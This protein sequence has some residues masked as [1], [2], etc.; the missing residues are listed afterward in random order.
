MTCAGPHLRCPPPKRLPCKV[1]I[2]VHLTAGS[3]DVGD[4]LRALYETTREAFEVAILVDPA[5]SEAT[6]VAA[7]LA[8]LRGAS[9]WCI[10]APGGG[11]ASF[12]KLV[13]EVADVYVFLEAGTRPGPG[14]LGLMLDALDADPTSGL[15]GPTTDWC[16][17]EQGD[18]APC[19]RTAQDVARHA[20][21]LAATHGRAW[22]E[23][24]PLYSL[25]DFCLVVRRAVVEALGE[26]DQSYG[27]GPC[28]EMD[29]GVRAARAGFASIWV[30]AAYVLRA[31]W[32]ASRHAAETALM[33]SSKRRYQ[34]RF[35]GRRIRD[36][37]GAPYRSHCR[38]DACANFAPVPT[39]RIRLGLLTPMPTVSARAADPPLISCVMPTRGRPRFVAQAIAYFRRQDYPNRELVIV[40]DDATDLPEHTGGPDI[41]LIRCAASIGAKRQAGAE[42]A[43]GDLIAHWDD[44]DWYAPERLSRQAAPI[45]QGVAD[46]T[47][48]SDVIFMQPAARR[49]WTVTPQLFARMFVEKVLGGALMF[50]R[51][52]WRRSGPYP[53]ISLREDCEFMARA[54]RDGARLCPM[55]G[56]EL[57]IYVRHGANTW[58]FDEGRFLAESDWIPIEEPDCLAADRVFY[59]G[60]AVRPPTPTP[61]VSDGPLVSCIMPTANRRNFVG[62]AIAQFLAQDYPRRELIVVDDGEASV[63]DLIPDHKSVHY[64]R[65][66]RRTPV[67]AKRNIACE[68]AQGEIIAHWDDDDWMASEWLRSQVETLLTHGA[69][70]CG[71]NNVL[72]Y[73]PGSRRGWR[74]VYDGQEPWVFGGTLCYAKAYWARAPFPRIDVGEDNAFVW[75]P[76]PKRI[77]N[78]AR[79]D[80][81]VAIVHQGNTSPKNTAGPRWREA[82][83]QERQALMRLEHDRSRSDCHC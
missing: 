51:D 3:Q 17:N 61:I 73:A 29:Y 63:A 76:Q 28:W 75:S 46:I 16:W 30:K 36:G 49:F 82:T 79:G 25:S 34:D 44:D 48:F 9:Q 43:R 47:A 4:T 72:F 70:I 68:V 74:Y 62:R 21:A 14:W 6:S 13:A 50:R 22:R 40:H 58:K 57:Y 26:A 18:K 27:R 35:C 33:E 1:L 5:P 54:M 77:A 31:P 2:G 23:M 71:L 12:N 66:G 42:A 65:L 20:T 55:P 45:R 15:A 38:G 59:F 80:L 53:A 81:Y 7:R 37:A 56:R 52:T 24:T 67:G 41:S 10:A 39:T 69:D 60:K 32:T 83:A 78:N 64:L 19:R 11:P 8:G